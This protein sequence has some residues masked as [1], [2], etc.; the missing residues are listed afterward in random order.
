MTVVLRYS[1]NPYALSSNLSKLC[2]NVVNNMSTRNRTH[3][4]A[5]VEHT[6]NVTA[7]NGMGKEKN[8]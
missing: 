5:F 8:K 3:I 4:G 2:H 6:R 1:A 7:E